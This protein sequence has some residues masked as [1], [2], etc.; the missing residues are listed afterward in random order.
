M[1]KNGF[2][3][4]GRPAVVL[5]GAQIEIVRQGDLPESRPLVSYRSIYDEMVRTGHGVRVQAGTAAQAKKIQV[6]AQACIRRFVGEKFRVCTRVSD[7]NSVLIWLRRRD[8]G[9]SLAEVTA[10]LWRCPE[11]GAIS[12]VEEHRAGA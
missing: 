10:L 9:E 2:G 3:G 4:A 12:T 11:C 7:D 5:A 8:E 1:N 6:S